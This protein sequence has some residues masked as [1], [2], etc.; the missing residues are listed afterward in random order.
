MCRGLY[1]CVYIYVC[2]VYVYVCIC[3]CV[4]CIPVCRLLC[5][6]ITQHYSILYNLLCT[7]FRWDFKLLLQ[8]LIIQ[9]GPIHIIITRACIRKEIIMPRYMAPSN[10]KIDTLL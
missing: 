7:N 10:K 4:M 5:C 2:T 6:C 3:M 1:E 8:I 9:F